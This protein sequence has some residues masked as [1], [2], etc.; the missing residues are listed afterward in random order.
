MSKRKEGNQQVT[1]SKRL[2]PDNGI[3]SFYSTKVIKNKVDNEITI[4]SSI[5]NLF[6]FIWWPSNFK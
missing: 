6:N 3:F 1:S 2:Q 5:S 4:L